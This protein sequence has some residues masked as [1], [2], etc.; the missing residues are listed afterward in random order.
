MRKHM[1]NARK[2]TIQTNRAQGKHYGQ[3]KP[4]LKRQGLYSEAE[5]SMP[6]DPIDKA[7]KY[8]KQ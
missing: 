7:R 6:L 3:T 5:W 8:K 2:Q 1:T 4:G